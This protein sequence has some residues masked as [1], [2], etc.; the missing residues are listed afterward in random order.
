MC[1]D[2]GKIRFSRRR[3]GELGAFF[4]IAV[5]TFLAGC[6]L[7]P[8][9][10]NFPVGVPT[11]ETTPLLDLEEIGAFGLPLGF[12]IGGVAKGGDAEILI[13]NEK[14]VFRLD[15]RWAELEPLELHGPPMRPKGVSA[16]GLGLEVV[17]AAS[18][19]LIRF[20]TDGTRAFQA[21]LSTAEWPLDGEL[22]DGEWAT[23]GWFVLVEGGDSRGPAI[24]LV[25]PSGAIAWKR[26]FP[27][28]DDTEMNRRD[29][30]L[31]QVVDGVLL[32]TSGPPFGV[33]RLDCGGE[34]VLH[35]QDLSAGLDSIPP[36]TGGERMFAVSTLALGEWYLQTL[37]DLSS[38]QRVLLVFDDRGV[39]RRI[40]ALE[41]PLGFAASFSAEANLVGIR[42]LEPAELVV[43]EW[44]LHQHGESPVK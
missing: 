33:T 25:E 28:E 35:F 2:S 24:L 15:T 5:L 16:S 3:I 7:G 8:Q 21:A 11:G 23:C 4:P 14:G 41:L 34:P 18:Q 6:D 27:R 40:R 42:Q 13:W 1:L 29:L 9:S 32:T 17:D 20:N 26:Q 38:D 12:S 19:Q 22:K 10:D 44:S 43:Y 30:F 39:L 31:D 36:S 37:T